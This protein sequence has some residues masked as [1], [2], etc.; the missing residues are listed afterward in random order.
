MKG[1]ILKKLKR[2]WHLSKDDIDQ[3]KFDVAMKLLYLRLTDGIPRDPKLD[4]REES[5]SKP[6]WYQM[7]PNCS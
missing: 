7:P 3:I 5:D 4:K 2:D 6:S 1:S